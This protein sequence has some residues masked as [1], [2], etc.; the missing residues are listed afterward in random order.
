M[1]HLSNLIPIV[2]LP[3][4]YQTIK[5]NSS[6]NIIKPERPQVVVN[7]ERNGFLSN[8]MQRISSIF[9]VLFSLFN[10][11]NLLNSNEDEARNFKSL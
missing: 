7:I 4:S 9:F 1:L 10:G 2:I 8:E 11:R 3:N 6:K 5:S